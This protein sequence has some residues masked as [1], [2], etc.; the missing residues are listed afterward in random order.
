MKN[1]QQYEMQYKSNMNNNIKLQCYLSNKSYKGSKT[2]LMPSHLGNRKSYA[3]KVKK[4]S[5]K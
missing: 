5:A 4:I 3:G 1:E 2:C